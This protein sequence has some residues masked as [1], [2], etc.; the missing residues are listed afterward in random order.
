[1]KQAVEVIVLGFTVTVYVFRS[2]TY[3][4]ALC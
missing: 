2:K 1:V 4:R 3:L